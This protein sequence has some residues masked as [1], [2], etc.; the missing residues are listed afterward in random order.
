MSFECVRVPQR[1]MPREISNPWPQ[2]T[3]ERLQVDAPILQSYT[4][5]SYC[6]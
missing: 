1:I 5:R 6:D 3:E 2:R 4:P